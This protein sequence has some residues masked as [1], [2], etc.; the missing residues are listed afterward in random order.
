MV[1]TVADVSEVYRDGSDNRFREYNGIN[2][3]SKTSW[4]SDIVSQSLI[5]IP[6]KH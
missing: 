3:V 1:I 2:R 4:H 6:H 5:L